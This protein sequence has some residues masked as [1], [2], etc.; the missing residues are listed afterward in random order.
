MLVSRGMGTTTARIRALGRRFVTSTRRVCF[1]FALLGAFCLSIAG[2]AHAQQAEPPAYREL[3]RQGLQ[4]FN[5]G[6]WPEAYAAFKRAHELFPN[7]RT[8]RSLG[9]S[10]FEARRYVAALEHLEAALTDTRRPLTPEQRAEVASFIDR[11]MGYVA[12]LSL[13]VTPADATIQVGAAAP[14]PVATTRELRLDPGPHD[15]LFSAPDHDPERLRVVVNAGERRELAIDLPA[16]G[17]QASAPAQPAQTGSSQPTRTSGPSA[18]S[19]MLGPYLVLG[20]GGALLVSAAVTG[21][22]AQSAADDL[23]DGCVQNVCD[24]KLESAKER[25]ETLQVATN[26]L[27]GVGAATVAAG[28]VYWLLQ[29]SGAPAERQGAALACGPRTCMVSYRSRF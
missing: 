14:V 16:S 11:A 10:A 6:N 4:E 23:E 9:V 8:Q 22:L 24:P 3:V 12:R 21:L 18:Q 29:S 15:L 1:G 2:A 13:T 7:A 26:V 19:S 20:T 28:G 17:A 5:R 27:L 25:G